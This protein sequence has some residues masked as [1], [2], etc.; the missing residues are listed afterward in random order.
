MKYYK[1]L[2]T[3]IYYISQLT[4]VVFVILALIFLFK[5]DYFNSVVFFIYSIPAYIQTR[6]AHALL[7]HELIYR[8]ISNGK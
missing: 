7:K 5:D 4:A 2:I 8:D 6:I 1:T 3:S